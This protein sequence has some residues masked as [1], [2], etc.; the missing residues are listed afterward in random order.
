MFGFD[1]C[2]LKYNVYQ[3][4]WVIMVSNWCKEMFKAL[5]EVKAH[6]KAEY[7]QFN[8]QILTDF[9]NMGNHRHKE[10]YN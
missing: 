2:I 6:A 1:F 10:S 4:F 5:V 8:I 9:K 3:D 7:P